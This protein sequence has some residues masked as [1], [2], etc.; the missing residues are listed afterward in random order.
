MIGRQFSPRPLG[1]ELDA[2]TRTLIAHLARLDPSSERRHVLQ[3]LAL[4]IGPWPVQ[5]RREAI[6][7]LVE[8]DIGGGRPAGWTVVGWAGP[9]WGCHCGCESPGSWCASSLRQGQPPGCTC[10]PSWTRCWRIR[11]DLA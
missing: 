5:A 3:R 1:V 4:R 10:P 6:A 7:Q 9:Y 8:V 11:H 2:D